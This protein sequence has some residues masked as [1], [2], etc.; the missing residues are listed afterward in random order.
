[1]H[2]ADFFLVLA[3]LISHEANGQT[4]LVKK[5]KKQGQVTNFFHEN[6]PWKK[7]P[8]YADYDFMEKLRC[9]VVCFVE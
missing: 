3:A 1:M 8:K 6:F 2:S 4:P 5:G 9:M 7:S